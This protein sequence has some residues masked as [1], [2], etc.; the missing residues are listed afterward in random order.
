MGDLIVVETECKYEEG[1]IIY[2]KARPTLIESILPP[3][4][5]GEP[6]ILKLLMLDDGL[7]NQVHDDDSDLSD[8]PNFAALREYYY[9]VTDKALLDQVEHQGRK[10]L[11]QKKLLKAL[12]DETKKLKQDIQ[13]LERGVAH[14]KVV[15][16]ARLRGRQRV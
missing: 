11:G 7:P 12:R 5:N 13:L 6:C 1:E 4:A 15:G 14:V 2:Y 16:P 10:L 3:R 8:E 9:R